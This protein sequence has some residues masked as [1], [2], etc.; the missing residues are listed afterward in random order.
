MYLRMKTIFCGSNCIVMY[1]MENKYYVAPYTDA[2]ETIKAVPIVQAA[3]SH[4]NPETG[5]TTIL[6]LN[7]DH[8]LV[9]PNQ[10]CAYE[11]TVQDKHFVESPIFIAT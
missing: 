10:M 8:T 5:D 4:N 1:F 3:T 7:K 11:M 2:Y 6:I 9:N